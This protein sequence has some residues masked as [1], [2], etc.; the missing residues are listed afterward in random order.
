MKGSRKGFTMIELMIVIVV[1]GVF[2]AMM[3]MSSTEAEKSARVQNIINNFDQI[4]KAVNAWYLD[5]MHRIRLG[6][7]NRPGESGVIL[8]G[9]IEYL[10]TF[11]DK[12]GDA[13]ILPYIQ[14]NDNI[15]LISH[16]KEKNQDS[17]YILRAVENGKMWYVTYYLGKADS[18]VKSKFA[19]RAKSIELFGTDK[20]KDSVNRKNFYTNHN[21]INMEVL[22][23]K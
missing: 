13:E 22:S 21:Y 18:R 14:H 12:G 1:I 15:K 9:K 4:R 2:A 8:N 23:L 16:N 10:S 5:N 3:I 11:M 7:D 17:A 19:G 20:I 6:A